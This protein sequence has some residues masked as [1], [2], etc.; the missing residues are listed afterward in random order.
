MHE[1]VPMISPDGEQRAVEATPAALVPLMIR[2]WRQATDEE[3]TDARP[4][5]GNQDLLRVPEAD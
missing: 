5:A 2:G 4:D 3:V 1:T